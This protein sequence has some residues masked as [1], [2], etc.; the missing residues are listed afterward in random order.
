MVTKD[1]PQE[2]G[3]IIS[4]DMAARLLMIVP[5]RIRQLQRE[6][7]IS[8]EHRGKVPLIS[9]VQGYIRFLQDAAKKTSKTAADSRVRDA[10]AAE[11]EMRND[12]RMRKLIPIEDATA[13]QDYLVGVVREVMN[14]IPARVTRDVELRRKIE[15][16]VNAAQ[17][18]IAEAL[19]ASA[20]VARKGGDLPNAG[21]DS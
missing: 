4:H 21:S 14:S 1:Q 12:E 20:D 17:V 3:N 16:E 8:K 5:D 11:I 19:R 13:A 10:R 2:T 9:A 6:G 7:Y 15:A 18:K